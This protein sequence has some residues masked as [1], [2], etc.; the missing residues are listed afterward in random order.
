MQELKWR[1][2]SAGG[3][4]AGL[5]TGNSLMDEADVR[6]A[7][8]VPALE[9]ELRIV[10]VLETSVYACSCFKPESGARCSIAAL[11]ASLPHAVCSWWMYARARDR[12]A[13]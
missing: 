9:Q 6:R 13:L 1:R 8:Q 10:G 7:Q 4:A 12:T 2:A 11:R 5:A 3:S